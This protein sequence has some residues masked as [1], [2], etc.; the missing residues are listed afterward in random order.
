[1]SGIGNAMAMMG[2][3]VAGRGQF[4]WQSWSV[5]VAKVGTSLAFRK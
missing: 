3:L 5:A 2:S 1:M 4:P